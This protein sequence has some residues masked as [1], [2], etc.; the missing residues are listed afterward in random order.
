MG[1]SA[2]DDFLDARGMS[3]EDEEFFRIFVEYDGLLWGASA[4]RPGARAR[5]YDDFTLRR[6]YR[7]YRSLAD[8]DAPV[9]FGVR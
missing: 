6:L 7:C 9:T 4:R 2:W 3:V 5:D 8:R 1:A